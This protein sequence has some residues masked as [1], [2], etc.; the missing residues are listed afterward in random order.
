[1][2][3]SS[4][5]VSALILTKY[6]CHHCWAPS[7]NTFH[8]SQTP[9]PCVSLLGHRPPLPGVRR[10]SFLYLWALS[11]GM[12]LA[13]S[14]HLSPVSLHSPDHLTG[15]ST[16]SPLHTL[17]APA[18]APEFRTWYHPYTSNGDPKVLVAQSCLTLCDP[19]AH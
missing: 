12:P 7:G 14:P 3:Q 1:M 10:G 16:F 13:H 17:A 11:T 8:T 6:R 9:L 15:P 4:G 18:F 5:P 2:P 19:T